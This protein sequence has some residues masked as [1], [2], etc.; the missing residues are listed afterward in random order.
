[1]N[2]NPHR[3]FFALLDKLMEHS[4]N[5][6]SHAYFR[7]GGEW[8][9]CFAEKHEVN[10]LLDAMSELSQNF[11]L[12]E[13]PMDPKL[14]ARFLQYDIS[15]ASRRPMIAAPAKDVLQARL[16]DLGAVR[17]EH[18]GQLKPLHRAS[19]TT[20][21]D[22][23]IVEIFQRDVNQAFDNYSLAENKKTSPTS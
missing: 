9:I 20:L 7:F 21:P 4:L 15:V 19:L 12:N 22:K 5:E 13:K 23:E 1:M 3:H 2:A 14:T 11:R 16:I 18:S 8:L 10:S 17:Q 6:R